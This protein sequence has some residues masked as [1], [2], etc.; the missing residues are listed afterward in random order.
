[1]DPAARGSAV[2]GRYGEIPSCAPPPGDLL[3]LED[4]NIKEWWSRLLTPQLTLLKGRTTHQVVSPSAS[5]HILFLNRR[6]VFTR[7]HEHCPQAKPTS[8]P[9]LGDQHA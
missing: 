7:I 8:Q 1:M 6:T 2:W 9:V 5:I 4:R 3:G